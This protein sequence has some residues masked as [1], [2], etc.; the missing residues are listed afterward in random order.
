MPR[1]LIRV[2]LEDTTL[3][4]DHLLDRKLMKIGVLNFVVVET[5]QRFRMP[6]GTYL[7][8][9]EIAADDLRLKI[10]DVA[11]DFRN[12]QCVVVAEAADFAWH[13]MM[14]IEPA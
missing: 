1:F 9:G 13:G 2:Y 5:G 14:P 8:D 7:F 12:W 6:P 11:Q 4:E 10:A 3:E